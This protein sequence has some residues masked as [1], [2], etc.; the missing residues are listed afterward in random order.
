MEQLKENQFTNL[1][2]DK[3]RVLLFAD[4]PRPLVK[5]F[6]PILS[7]AQTVRE[8]LPANQPIGVLFGSFN[9]SLLAKL[10]PGSIIGIDL[11][12]I[13]MI[14]TLHPKISYENANDVDILTWPVLFYEVDR[15][16][17]KN[18]VVTS[19][20]NPQR[21]ILRL[22][23]REGPS[24]EIHTYLEDSDD[25][26]LQAARQYR[27]LSD[28]VPIGTHTNGTF[29]LHDPYDIL[30]RKCPSSEVYGPKV[31][32]ILARAAEQIKQPYELVKKMVSVIISNPHI[33][34][35]DTMRLLEDFLIPLLK[36]DRP[37]TLAEADSICAL[38]QKK[39]LAYLD[40]FP[41]VI[42]ILFETPP[43][44]HLISTA[45]QTAGRTD[46]TDH[47]AYLATKSS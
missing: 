41:L 25:L 10:Y 30:Q 21:R 24:I 2:Y 26:V 16:N 46:I 7:A 44:C 6:Q 1:I 13:A 4:P 22:K 17:P 14:T 19:R 40:H 35:A 29:L 8:Q 31:I 34:H 42:R 18:P 27:M 33:F 28:L 20:C 38:L 47:F 15:R 9:R 3:S 36:I 11:L 5:V 23:T 32:E 37:P 39:S 45:I 43:L 12:Q